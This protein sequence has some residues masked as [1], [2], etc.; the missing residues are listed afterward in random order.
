MIKV[1]FYGHLLIH[2]GMTKTNK[3]LLSGK[4]VGNVAR[5]TKIGTILLQ[6]LKY[7]S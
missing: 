1:I 5:S 4:L 3:Y 7:S 2:G 6:L